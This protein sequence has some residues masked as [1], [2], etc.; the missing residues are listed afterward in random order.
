MSLEIVSLK[1][2][3]RVCFYVLFLVGDMLFLEG[4]AYGLKFRLFFL[5][6]IFYS[7]A[8]SFSFSLTVSA[9]T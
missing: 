4:L 5:V 2:V 7:S 3:F 1:S 8:S 6:F 9:N